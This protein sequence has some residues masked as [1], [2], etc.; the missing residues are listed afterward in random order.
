MELLNQRLKTA[1]EEL[2]AIRNEKSKAYTSSGDT[3]HDNPYFNKLEQDE[4]R[5]AAE[6]TELAALVASAQEFE[7]GDRNISHVQLGSIVRLLRLYA[8]TQEE[9]E[10]IFEVSGY[11]ETDVSERRVAYN[12][13]M[14]KVLMGLQPGDT[15]H[16]SGPKGSVEYEILELYPDWSTVPQTK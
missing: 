5:K 14:M 7:V 15:V 4:K 13:P 12:S 1:N 9:E 6:T 11:G 3:W 8:A 2:A 10:L 16:A